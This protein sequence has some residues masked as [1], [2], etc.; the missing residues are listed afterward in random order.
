MRTKDIPF[1]GESSRSDAAR[2]E[3]G[4]GSRSYA[5]GELEGYAAGGRVFPKMTAGAGSGV[6]RLEKA[7]KDVKAK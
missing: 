5:D 4:G 3:H 7:G 2:R 1:S 6:G